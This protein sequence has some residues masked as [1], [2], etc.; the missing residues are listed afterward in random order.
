MMWIQAV[1]WHY[2]L[3]KRNLSRGMMLEDILVVGEFKDGEVSSTTFEL[4]AAANHLTGNVLLALFSD[5]FDDS[6]SYLI[7]RGADRVFLV[8]HDLLS[9]GLT[10]VHVEALEQVCH[11]VSPSILLLGNTLMGRETGPRVAF[12]LSAGL[13]QDCTN[14]SRN[15]ETGRVVAFRPVYGGIAQAAVTFPGD[16]VQIATVRAGSYEPLDEDTERIGEIIPFSVEI[17]PSAV[18]KNRIEV[19]NTEIQ[20]V[21]LEDAKVVVA[22]GRGLG[23]AEPFILLQELASLLGGTVGAS[24]AACDA[25]WIDHNSQIGLTGKTVAPN[26]YITVGISGASQHMAGCSGS[27]CIVA[28]NHDP[29]AN[30]FSEAD[31]GVVGDWNQILPSF[32][33]T[34]RELI[35]S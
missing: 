9:E 25:G 13:A 15:E 20:G 30:I 19:V 33:E 21:K 11:Q 23:G 8:E 4:L 2:D 29:N 6:F 17:K 32:I 14:L 5:S 22:G 1:T 26:I 18:K 3:K 10:D 7:S 27:R 28:I 16:S 34:V 12:R 35:N 24:R 31:F